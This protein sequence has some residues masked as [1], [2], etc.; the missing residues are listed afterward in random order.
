M[1]F[2]EVKWLKVIKSHKFDIEGLLAAG[3]SASFRR[4]QSEDC[5]ML[6]KEQTA[7]LDMQ[8]K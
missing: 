7:A 8:W 2:R 4:L 3:S 6:K 5:P 1:P